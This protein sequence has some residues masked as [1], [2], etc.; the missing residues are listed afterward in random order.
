MKLFLVDYHLEAGRLR[1]AE[2]EDAEAEKHFEKAARMIKETG[3]Y[4]RE[5][6]VEGY[7]KRG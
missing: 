2:G 7:E 4:R 5:K 6:G 3:Y 1:R